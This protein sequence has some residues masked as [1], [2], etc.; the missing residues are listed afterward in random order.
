MLTQLTHSKGGGYKA[1]V[2][3]KEQKMAKPLLP[4]EVLN[5]VIDVL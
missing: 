1:Q 5:V 4:T 3:L 2:S